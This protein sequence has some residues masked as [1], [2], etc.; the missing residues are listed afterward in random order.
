MVFNREARVIGIIFACS[1]LVF[2]SWASFIP[3]IREKLSLDEA[4]LGMLLLSMPIGVFLVNPISVILIQKF[5]AFLTALTFVLLTGFAFLIPVT[6]PSIPLVVIGL[7]ISGAFFGITNVSMNTSA[8]VLEETGNIRFIS[9]CH[10]MWSLG[11]MC[12]AFF[13]GLSLRPFRECCHHLMDPQMLYVLLQ[14]FIVTLIIC[15]LFFSSRN[16]RNKVNSS[17]ESPRITWTMIKPGKELWM[18]IIVCLCTYLAEGAITDW[19]AVYL[20]DEMAAT[21][22]RAGRGFA[23]YAFFM[24]A[25]RFIGDAFI[26]KFGNIQVL[27]AGGYLSFLGWL[28]IIASPLY[29]LSIAGFALIGAGISLASPILYKASSKVKG[30]AQGVGL[31]TMNTF[32]MATFL[33]GPVVIG[34]IAEKFSLRI[35]FILVLLATVIW[36]FQSSWMIRKNFSVVERKISG[37][38]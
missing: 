31:A 4:E 33:G 1:G 18:I 24:A 27:R 8:S 21:Q 22:T 16:L 6:S 17:G 19:S 3:Y 28:I 10:G 23:F 14:A 35:S 26:S 20:R 34:L 2:G 37:E 13:S 11:A 36:I 25:G 5:G 30:L 7:L 12:G 38:R 32:A 29:W 9:A 15:L